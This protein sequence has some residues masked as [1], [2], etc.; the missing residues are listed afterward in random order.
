MLATITHQ[1]HRAIITVLLAVIAGATLILNVDQSKATPGHGDGFCSEGPLPF[2]QYM[3][4]ID[5]MG[6]HWHHW[7]DGITIQYSE[8]CYTV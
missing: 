7:G 3:G 2:Y 6:W 1:V 8:K 4:W 5:Y